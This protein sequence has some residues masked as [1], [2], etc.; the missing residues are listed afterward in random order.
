[1]ILRQF[2]VNVHP[3]VLSRVGHDKL[4]AALGA[5][6]M[7]MG[8]D[9]RQ[10]GGDLSNLVVWHGHRKGYGFWSTRT[11]PQD[12]VAEAVPNLHGGQQFLDPTLTACE[13]R[14]FPFRHLHVRARLL[15]L[16]FGDPRYVSAG[17]GSATSRML[18]GNATPTA[19]KTW[20]TSPVTGVR[21]RKRLPSCSVS[22]SCR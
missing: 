2:C 20:P 4:P 3:M 17:S 13:T 12:A 14:A 21:N 19:L 10:F 5:M 8:D 16:R 9:A 6:A 1:M 7:S 22:I 15:A 11:Q 18:G